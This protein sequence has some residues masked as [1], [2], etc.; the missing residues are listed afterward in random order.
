MVV[1]AVLLVAG[2]TVTPSAQRH[3]PYPFTPAPTNESTPIDG[4]YARDV[5]DEALGGSAPC[6]RCPPYKLTLGIDVIGFDQGAFRAYHWGKGYEAVGNYIVEGDTVALFNDAWC[7]TT[8]GVYRVEKREDVTVF[9]AV[10][11]PC[12]FD[13][14]RTTYLEVAPWRTLF[15]PEGVYL[16]D[17][18]SSLLVMDG[19]VV[20]RS[21]GARRSGTY[22]VSGSTIT[23]AVDECA[24][25]FRWSQRD[26]VIRL[27]AR[28]R[29]SCS[30]NLPA[31]WYSAT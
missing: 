5:P 29:G 15:P 25:Q 11:D 2:C 20:I 23:I 27:E 21:G 12:A 16:S 9:Q 7:P 8:R 3:D 26:G 14:V 22:T 13:D 17:D 28:G 19:M 24:R 4:R 31:A 6:I 18:G 30:V 10:D 1:G